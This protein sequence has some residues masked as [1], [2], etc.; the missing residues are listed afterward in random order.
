MANFCFPEIV[1]E[2][3]HPVQNAGCG[4]F[5]VCSI[6]KTSSWLQ[7]FANC[8]RFF[9]KLKKMV[10]ELAIS[11]SMPASFGKEVDQ[12]SSLS[13]GSEK[14]SSCQMIIRVPSLT[15]MMLSL[16]IN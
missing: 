6:A 12:M 8:Y 11:G 4:F 16:P 1:S 7:L 9:K 15:L 2:N 5:V 10:V 3:P 13:V 14:F